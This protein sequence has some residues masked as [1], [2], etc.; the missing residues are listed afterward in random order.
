MIF[1]DEKR[2]IIK[3][4][5]QRTHRQNVKGKQRNK[6]TMLDQSQSLP[7][8]YISKFDMLTSGSC[9]ACSHFIFMILLKWCVPDTYYKT[10]LL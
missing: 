3:N 6:E 7:V 9:N 4:L 5:A 1:E 2:S 10:K 8:F